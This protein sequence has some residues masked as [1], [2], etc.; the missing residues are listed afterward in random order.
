MVRDA[1]KDAFYI[2]ALPFFSMEPWV[3]IDP[4]IE[5]VPLVGDLHVYPLSQLKYLKGTF[6]FCLR[7]LLPV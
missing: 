4:A 2:I 7:V 5:L 6:Y 1:L 3:K